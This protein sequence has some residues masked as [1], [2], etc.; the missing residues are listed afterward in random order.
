MAATEAKEMAAREAKTAFQ[1]KFSE[2]VAELLPAFQPGTASL[3]DHMKS[4][5]GDLAEGIRS[6]MKL[7]DLQLF[8]APADAPEESS[9]SEDYKYF[10]EGKV[11]EMKPLTSLLPLIT[12]TGDGETKPGDWKM[13]YEPEKSRLWAFLRM[14]AKMQNEA[15]MGNEHIRDRLEKIKNDLLEKLPV[16][17]AS[18]PLNDNLA[19]MDPLVQFGCVPYAL[20]IHLRLRGRTRGS[21]PENK[22]KQHAWCFQAPISWGVVIGRPGAET[23]IRRIVG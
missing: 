18:W 17:I 20:G 15:L 22:S 2:E 12:V 14:L 16:I 10:Y 13:L 3:N 19:G 7:G 5:S 9:V 1:K 23:G 6:T 8:G 4:G 21:T 11:K